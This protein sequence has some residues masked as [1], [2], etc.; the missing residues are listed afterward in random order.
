[1]PLLLQKLDGDDDPSQLL[2]DVGVI[3]EWGFALLTHSP[4]PGKAC[5]GGAASSGMRAS[6]LVVFCHTRI[7]YEHHKSP[8]HPFHPFI[9]PSPSL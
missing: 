1:M 5:D 3:V 6:W 8:F 4:Q 2:N 7:S 9:H